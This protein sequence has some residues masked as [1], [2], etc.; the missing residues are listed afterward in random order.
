M[1]PREGVWND[2][3]RIDTIES[4]RTRLLW[5]PSGQRYSDEGN[6]LSYVKAGAAIGIRHNGSFEIEIKNISV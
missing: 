4:A 2:V 5:I 1:V 3:K 6:D